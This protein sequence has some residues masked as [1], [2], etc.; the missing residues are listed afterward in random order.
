VASSIIDRWPGITIA[1]KR[2]TLTERVAQVALNEAI[3]KVISAC[4]C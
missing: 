1:Q 4:C 2:L 3:G